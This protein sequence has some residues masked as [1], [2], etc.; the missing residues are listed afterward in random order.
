MLCASLHEVHR[1]L[2]GDCFPSG[3]R[4]PGEQ[5]GQRHARRR[6]RDYSTRC[7][8]A[9]FGRSGSRVG[10]RRRGSAEPQVYGRVLPRAARPWTIGPTV[11]NL[12][13][14]SGHPMP[15]QHGQ[16]MRVRLRVYGRSE[17]PLLPLGGP[18]WARRVFLRRMLHRLAL[19]IEDAVPLP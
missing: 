10:E 18:H 13:G 4:R 15:G 5:D 2:D 16:H 19:W 12:L 9:N 8:R 7:L 3:L 1:T 17:R 6:W 14:A 11:S